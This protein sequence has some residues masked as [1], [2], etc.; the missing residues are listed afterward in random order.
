[1]PATTLEPT[2]KA[3]PVVLGRV[4]SE[5]KPGKFFEI[6]LGAD[7]KVYCTCPS[8]KFHGGATKG[9]KHTRAFLDTRS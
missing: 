7:D 2:V 1:M 6:R 8:W 4:E 3:V 9:C 5:S